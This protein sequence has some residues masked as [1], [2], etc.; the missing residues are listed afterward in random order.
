MTSTGPF[1]PSPCY[2][3]ALKKSNKQKKPNKQNNQTMYLKILFNL[4]NVCSIFGKSMC[5][6]EAKYWKKEK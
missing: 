3:S 6:V 2:D 5:S 1:Q 4:E